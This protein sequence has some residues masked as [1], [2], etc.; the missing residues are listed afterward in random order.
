MFSTRL[1]C[2]TW[3]HSPAFTQVFSG[4]IDVSIE[5][6]PPW[7]SC[8]LSSLQIAPVKTLTADTDVEGVEA[9]QRT[10]IQI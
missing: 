1:C 9:K 5:L 2:V 10:R 4:Q 7:F 8:H 6:L 3:R